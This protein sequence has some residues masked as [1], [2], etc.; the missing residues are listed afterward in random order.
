MKIQLQRLF[1]AAALLVPLWCWCVE[2]IW[3]TLPSDSSV[4]RY[5]GLIMAT[6]GLPYVDAWDHKG[7]IVY[8]LNALGYWLLPSWNCGPGLVY[9]LVWQA[10][11]LILYF[12]V[13]K[14]ED[15][16]E[17]GL[18]AFLFSFFACGIQGGAFQNCVEIGAL[19]FAALGVYVWISFKSQY[20]Y[21][22]IGACV[23]MAFLSK[24]NFIS[25]GGAMALVW[26]VEAVCKRELK[27]LIVCG[28]L[29][30]LGCF[31][32]IGV[33]TF[34]LYPSSYK[35]MWDGLLLFNL[36]EYR[37]EDI[38]LVDWWI[39]YFS[40]EWNL[41]KA[42]GWLLPTFAGGL[43]VSA[44]NLLDK[45][46]LG[47]SFQRYLYVWLILEIMMAF[48]FKVFYSHYL[49]MVYMPLSV[50][51]ARIALRNRRAIKCIAIGYLLFAGTLFS[52]CYASGWRSY[53]R[54]SQNI[55]T[56]RAYARDNIRTEESV[57][58]YGGHWA[59]EALSSCK[60]RTRQKY[61][62]NKF[63]YDDAN[64]VRQ[65]EM[66]DELHRVLSDTNVNWF[67]LEGSTNKMSM[68]YGDKRI[69]DDLTSFCLEK[70]FPSVKFYKRI[71]NL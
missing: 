32:V 64:V 47:F 7:P 34:M 13:K 59:L 27:P 8:F 41:F 68:A 42:G 65:Q 35:E 9:M 61:Q 56:I 17:A 29:S 67:I 25:F 69:S 4:F 2:I 16:L 43:V 31:C 19:L 33:I 50:L 5:D 26:V 60:I 66:R 48:A 63:L 57:A 44:T 10:T 54:T 53:K 58:V 3:G 23:G 37:H 11:V 36:L 20:K 28:G 46:T 49:M 70:S 55:D 40:E 30:A 1:L 71:N 38:S 24:P 21:F 18:S 39:R 14:I 15:E 12:A 51:L 6:G 45:R 22:L 52:L 62:I